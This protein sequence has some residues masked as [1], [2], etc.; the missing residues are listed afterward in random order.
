MLD[1]AVTLLEEIWPRITG[2]SYELTMV[3]PSSRLLCMLQNLRGAEVKGSTA[4]LSDK[5][6]KRTTDQEEHSDDDDDDVWNKMDVVTSSVKR[7]R[8]Q[9][10]KN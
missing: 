9:K 5:S 8:L 10:S 4:A 3:K 7:K 6:L 2:P 1:V